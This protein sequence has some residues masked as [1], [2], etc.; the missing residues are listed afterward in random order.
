MV[1]EMA[2]EMG[3]GRKRRA[4]FGVML[5]IFLA[6]MESTVVA[7]AM[8]KVVGSL[9]GIEIYSWVFSGFLLTSTVMMPL[10]GRLSDL[11]GR[12]RTYLA[13]LVVFLAGSALSGL[14]QDMAQLI[15]FRMLQGVGAGSL[16]T[17]GMTIVGE[18]FGLERRAKMQGYISGVWGVASLLGP[19]IGG[20][21]TDFVSWRWIFYIN[22]PFGAVAMALL[23]NALHRDAGPRRRP[24]IDY[25]GV[26]LFAFGVTA[27]LFG[28]LEAGRVSAWDGP[29][30]LGP[31]LAAAVALVLFVR[32]EQRAAEPIVPL[33]LFGNRVVVAAVVTGFLAG[34]AMFGALSFVPLYL[35]LVM[36]MSATGAGVV[37]IPFVL[38]W[39]G[40]SV[41]SARLVLRV[42]Y[43]VVVFGGMACLMLSFVLLTRW[44]PALTQAAAMRD[45]LL[46]GM[47]MGMNMVPM[48]IAVQSAVA[49]A[50]LGAA[51]SMTQF[52]R[53]I[54]GA[55]G[56]SVMGAVMAQRR[57]GGASMDDALHGVF[58]VGLVVCVVA[59][60]S[61]F[62][63]PAGRAQD[64][65]RAEVRGEPTRAGG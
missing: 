19:L 44:S 6:A 14:A 50:D 16:M 26:S 24:V 34:M 27:L 43:R 10:W 32:V 15:V 5:S 58:I 62:L 40:M 38:G 22:L 17:I 28:V 46:A 61:A 31:L 55:V 33:R 8:P 57:S 63:V 11:F 35:Q 18:L 12:R 37:L 52:F 47:G 51:T 25:A 1:T 9:G 13:G 49:R 59:F 2:T 54:G 4:L 23:A 60:A 30:V 42:G 41:V 45:A 3:E 64:L 29:D 7:T 53:T 36:G 20:L 65:A 21:L 39:V 48:L 56:L